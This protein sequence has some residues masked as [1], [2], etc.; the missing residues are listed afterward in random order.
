MPLTF[1]QALFLISMVGFMMIALDWILGK[2]KKDWKPLP[3]ELEEE[4][5]RGHRHNSPTT[6]EG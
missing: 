1:S 4:E 2:V 6:R 5:A 3:W